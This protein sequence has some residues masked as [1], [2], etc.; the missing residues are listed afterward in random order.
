LN[1]HKSNTIV[2]TA[3]DENG[4]YSFKSL[5]AGEYEM[6]VVKRGFE[7]YRAQPVTLESGRDLSQNLTLEVAAIMEEVEVVPAGTSKP[8]PETGESRLECASAEKS[9]YKTSPQGNAGLSRCRQDQRHAGHRDS[10]CRH[11]NRRQTVVPPRH[12]QPG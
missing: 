10:S 3:S 5:P 6:K 7:P 2:M 9:S 1:S 11:R 8:L 12:E 4:N